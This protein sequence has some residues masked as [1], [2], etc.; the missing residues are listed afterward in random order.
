MQADRW[1]LQSC[2]L[3][4]RGRGRGLGW[5]GCKTNGGPG[6]ASKATAGAG[7]GAA[8]ATARTAPAPAPAPAP[9]P[10]FF[11][12]WRFGSLLLHGNGTLHKSMSQ[13]HGCSRYAEAPRGSTK[14]DGSNG[15]VNAF[16]PVFQGLR[17]TSCLNRRSVRGRVG[18]CAVPSKEGVCGRGWG[19]ASPVACERIGVWLDALRPCQIRRDLVNRVGIAIAGQGRAGQDRTSNEWRWDSSSCWLQCDKRP[20]SPWARGMGMGMGMGMDADVHGSPTCLYPAPAEAKAFC[21]LTTGRVG[22]VPTGSAAQH[23]PKH[24]PTRPLYVHTTALDCPCRTTTPSTCPPRAGAPPATQCLRRDTQHANARQGVWGSRRDETCLICMYAAHAIISCDMSAQSVRNRRCLL[25]A[26]WQSPSSA[27]LA[28][29][30][31]PE[32]SPVPRP[33]HLPWR[34]RLQ[35]AIS[36]FGLGAN[37]RPRFCMPATMPTL[38]HWHILECTHTSCSCRGDCSTPLIQLRRYATYHRP[39]PQARTRTR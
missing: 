32:Y 5:A 20:L 6:D 3:C 36:I 12:P 26:G 29:C 31:T 33:Q 2:P 35:A 34:D 1:L 7:A 27:R 19:V 24:D 25:L 39:R 15:A 21:G 30:R 11:A 13:R 10:I 22:H 28:S 16:E 37:P 23:R 9:S 14:E 18:I 38:T 4:G 8:V 17:D